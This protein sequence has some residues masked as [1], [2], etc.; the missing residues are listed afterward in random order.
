MVEFPKEAL[1]NIAM[2]AVSG[3]L[4]GFS[5]AFV[6]TPSTSLPDLGSA[7]YGAAVLGLYS[8]IKEVA[9]Y[10]Q[11]L[12][13]GKATAAGPKAAPKPLLKRML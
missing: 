7:I 9:A 5:A 13:S 6:A 1:T 4:L 3:F 10:I 2:H 11:T 8:C 12:V